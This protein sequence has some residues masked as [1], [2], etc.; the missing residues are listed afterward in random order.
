[1]TVY[2]ALC[3]SM[4][5]WSISAELVLRRG[6]VPAIV[7]HTRIEVLFAK[8]RKEKALLAAEEVDPSVLHDGRSATPPGPGADRA[9]ASINTKSLARLGKWNIVF[10][11]VHLGAGFG[12][13][14]AFC[15]VQ[16]G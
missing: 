2:S 12:S 13:C 7:V 9:I 8:G 5:I 6:E 10:S 16:V 15:S 14:R 3:F 11:F 1:M 4:A